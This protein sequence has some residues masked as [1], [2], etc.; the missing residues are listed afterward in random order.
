MFSPASATPNL[1]MSA[2]SICLESCEQTLC[3][4][5]MTK[6][7]FKSAQSSLSILVARRIEAFEQEAQREPRGKMVI[8]T[9]RECFASAYCMASRDLDDTLRLTL[10]SHAPAWLTAKVLAQRPHALDARRA[11]L[12]KFAKDYSFKVAHAAAC[13]P[14]GEH[15]FSIDAHGASFMGRL[16][17]SSQWG[18]S[19]KNT[20]IAAS[21]TLSLP[22]AHAAEI[23][24]RMSRNAWNSENST[25]ILDALKS[26]VSFPFDAAS[27]L[28]ICAFAPPGMQGKNIGAWAALARGQVSTEDLAMALC[29]CPHANIESVASM[30][31]RLA[32]PH[33]ALLH[34]LLVR[35]PSAPTPARAALATL[36]QSWSSAL[37]LSQPESLL[38]LTA[39]HQNKSSP[40]VLGSN[41][42]EL[43]LRA[44]LSNKID[45]GTAVEFAALQSIL[46]D[47]AKA[48]MDFE[49]KL[50]ADSPST[51]EKLIASK[52]KQAQ[53]WMSLLESLQL[54][55][56]VAPLVAEESGRRAPRL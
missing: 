26:I 4:S 32:D 31:D 50:G 55:L 45:A 3:A 14:D 10:T 46:I 40:K 16:L 15:L 28:A 35:L 51:M 2:F 53:T 54:R 44:A 21:K 12:V 19:K 24:F 6:S 29:S 18:A 1:A 5:P 8:E 52:N 38:S 17:E 7:A 49:K 36:A 27:A 22:D 43:A 33:P 30:V 47:S 11:A 9:W 25:T 13:L 37:L 39:R 34:Y 23:E 42:A 56:A 20:L 41:A 48:G